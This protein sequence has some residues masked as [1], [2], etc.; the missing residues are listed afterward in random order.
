LDP[1]RGFI[2]SGK[3]NALGPRK[4]KHEDGAASTNP[5]LNFYRLYPTTDMVQRRGGHSAIRGVYEELKLFLALTWQP[6]KSTAVVDMFTWNADIVQKA[7]IGKLSAVLALET[8][9]VLIQY[10]IELAYDLMLARGLCVSKNPGFERFLN[11]YGN[12]DR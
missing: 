4:K 9:A 12:N 8:K 2:R 1:E 7:G 11:V 5:V 10:L 3:T 6:K